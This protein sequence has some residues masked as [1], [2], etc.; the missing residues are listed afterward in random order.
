MKQV[1][2]FRIRFTRSIAR[3][4]SLY[5]LLF[6][7][8]W[9][10]AGQLL[11]SILMG[12]HFL[13]LTISFAIGICVITLIPVLKQ[14]P[15]LIIFLGIAL[16]WVTAEGAGVV[17]GSPIPY[18]QESVLLYVDTP[19]RFRRVGGMEISARV[20]EVGKKGQRGLLWERIKDPPRILCRAPHLP[21]RQISRADESSMF[22][23]KIKLRNLERSPNP[24]TVDAKN[25]REGYAGT[26]TIVYTGH[27]V[28]LKRS[29]YARINEY[30]K[31]RTQQSVGETERSG[32]ILS[33]ALGMRDVLAERTERAFKDTGLAHLLV[34]SGYQVTLVYYLMYG[35]LRRISM[36]LFDWNT[37]WSADLPASLVALTTAL[38]FVWIVGIEGPTLRAGLATLFVV[39]SIHGERGCSM[40]HGILFSFLMMIILWPCIFCEPGVQL[41]F[42]ALLGI[43]LGQDRSEE[44]VLFAYLRVCLYA[45]LSTAF[46][47]VF[48]FERFSLWGFILNPI[49]APLLGVVS[50]HGGLL[51]LAL[52]LL[53]IDE[54]GILLGNVG[55]ILSYAAE[56]IRALAMHRWGAWDITG[57][58]RTV[59]M[60]GLLTPLILRARSVLRGRLGPRVLSDKSD[61][62][63][64]ESDLTISEFLAV[65]IR[66]RRAM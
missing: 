46:V 36:R 20:L 56:C 34:V 7:I 41:T 47:M 45:S 14:S 22:I 17:K 60:A 42:A 49:L 44:N 15:F 66:E 31:K 32:L 51:G 59:L 57:N 12:R 50:C 37:Q 29:L 26:C 23:A 28:L 6:F 27:V 33:M 55:D 9:V 63:T 24:F 61:H 10:V 2:L 38:S 65:S 8:P 54:R 18:S 16:G 35:L 11:N 53:G 62:G 58:A 1:N 19:P 64:S 30:I 4:R 3:L 48:W 40:F 13:V 52:L 5:P 21:W 43:A 39:I 25:I